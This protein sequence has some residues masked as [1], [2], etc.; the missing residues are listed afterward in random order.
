MSSGTGPYWLCNGASSFDGS[1]NDRTATGMERLGDPP[2][3]VFTINKDAGHHH[4][5]PG[6]FGAFDG[7]SQHRLA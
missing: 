4:A 6:L 1:K 2:R 3:F 7:F 5:V